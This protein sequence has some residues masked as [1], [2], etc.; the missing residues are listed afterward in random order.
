MEGKE[1]QR[2]ITWSDLTAFQ[3]RKRRKRKE[4]LSPEEVILKECRERQLFVA[5]ERERIAHFDHYHKAALVIQKAW[6]MFKF[7]TKGILKN[8]R[9]AVRRKRLDAGELEWKQ[10]IAACTIQ[11]A[12]RKYA[13]R[14]LLAR[15]KRTGSLAVH[16]WDPSML[17]M[18]QKQ[19]MQQI[20][21]EYMY[22]PSWHP[23]LAAPSRPHWLCQQ[24]SPAALSF[25][26]AIDQ[27]SQPLTYFSN[28]YPLEERRYSQLEELDKQIQGDLAQLQ[29]NHDGKQP[30]YY[31]Y[32]LT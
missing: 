8:A 23:T 26:Y 22:A 24:P 16:V 11:L 15:I 7:K 20:Y 31:S 30:M 10:Q 6:K 4:D 27:Y 3:K 25:N 1:A 13:R 29:V 5:A 14:Q 28:C 32:N 17:S 9:D 18:K 19:L 12:W 21:G 2:E